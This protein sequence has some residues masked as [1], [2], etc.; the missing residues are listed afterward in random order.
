MAQWFD[1]IGGKPLVHCAK[2]R[3][4]VNPRDTSG[5]QE[6][7]ATANVIRASGQ[8]PCHVSQDPPIRPASPTHHNTKKMTAATGAPQCRAIFRPGSM[9]V[10]ISAAVVCFLASGAD[11]NLKAR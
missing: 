6:A 4:A 2:R 1:S 10:T 7:E 5:F 9:S 8:F 3:A 11:L